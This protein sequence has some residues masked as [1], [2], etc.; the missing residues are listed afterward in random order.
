MKCRLVE[1][2]IVGLSAQ[3]SAWQIVDQI[4]TINVTNLDFCCI[5]SFVQDIMAIVIKFGFQSLITDSSV[6]HMKARLVSR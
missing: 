6:L 3:L 1:M 5:I 4:K 2:H